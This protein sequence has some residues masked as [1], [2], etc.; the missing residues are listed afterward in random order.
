MET[1]YFGNDFRRKQLIVIT[2][3]SIDDTI[4]WHY[5]VDHFLV[6]GAFF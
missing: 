1:S 3:K 4:C 2:L 6:S 5:D